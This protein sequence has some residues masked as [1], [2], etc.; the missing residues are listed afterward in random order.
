MSS[1]E[2]GSSGENPGLSRCTRCQ[3]P[4]ERFAVVVAYADETLRLCSACACPGRCM[5][6]RGHDGAHESIPPEVLQQPEKVF[7]LSSRS[8]TQAKLWMDAHRNACTEEG[9]PSV[10]GRWSYTFVVTSLG[11]AASVRCSLCG[12]WHD[13][14]DFADW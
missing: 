6:K 11:Y 2:K 8:A 13:V 5:K 7:R 9:T 3:A 10:G 12:G 4:C 14:T 1:Q